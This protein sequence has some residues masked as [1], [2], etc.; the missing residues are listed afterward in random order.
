VPEAAVKLEMAPSTLY[1]TADDYPFTMRQ[2]RRLKF[3]SCGI[4][5]W[6]QAGGRRAETGFASEGDRWR[7]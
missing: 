1:K 6:I 3:S 7:R 4:E 2:G 5:R